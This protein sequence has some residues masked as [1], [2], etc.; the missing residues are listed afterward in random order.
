MRTKN[1]LYQAA[2]RVVSARRQ[3]ARARAEDERAAAEAAIPALRHAEEEVRVRGIRCA[4]AG[5]KGSDR[6]AAAEALAA[7][8]Q[9]LAQLLAASGRA[10]DCL[11]PRFT[12]KLCQDTGVTDGHTCA[13]VRRVM[14]QLRR[15]E[16]EQLSSLK[17]ASFDT[18]SLDY[19][20]NLRDAQTG[21]PIR[22]Y[23]AD[24][25]DDLKAYADD[26][27]A[28][29]ENLMLFGNAG[30]GKTHAALAVAGVVLDKGYDVIYVSSPNFFS[31]LEDLR[32]GDDPNGERDALMETA[33]NA[34]LLILD[35][36]GTE[37]NSQYL[38]SA[39][40]TLLNTRL[41]AHR[42]TIITTNIMDGAVLEKRYTE[43][44]SSRI[45]AFV[46]FR[47]LGQDVRAAKAA[48][49]V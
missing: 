18:L 6:A 36:L 25:L 10:P 27:D 14:Q 28:N 4:L 30:L 17:V 32:F 31:R 21:K 46:P 22:L 16:I 23:M 3:V 39:L 48:E 43:K 42:P 12:C 34:D 13:C 24:V 8:K 44:I 15:E 37:F 20:P 19:Y 9:N 45:A 33:L 1:E 29:S 41:G 49:D 38:L 5:A 47:F 26:F 11:E 40:Y 7:A 35:D 2:L